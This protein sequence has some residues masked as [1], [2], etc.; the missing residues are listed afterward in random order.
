MKRDHLMGFVEQPL[1][2]LAVALKQP[3]VEIGYSLI[4]ASDIR[5]QNEYYFETAQ[6]HNPDGSYTNTPVQQLHFERD[7]AKFQ[8][9]AAEVPH[10]QP[11]EAKRV[12]NRLDPAKW[13][14]GRLPSVRDVDNAFGDGRLSAEWRRKWL[15]LID[16][17]AGRLSPY[18]RLYNAV[19]QSG[20]RLAAEFHNYT[21]D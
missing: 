15:E 12:R 18:E 19:R 11:P 9:R 21:K 20:G 7:Q 16:A 6:W 2:R 5:K 3:K 13:D 1:D 4:S 8:Q 14:G 10:Q 17:N